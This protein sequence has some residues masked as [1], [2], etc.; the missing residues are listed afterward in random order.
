MHFLTRLSRKYDAVATVKRKHLLFIPIKGIKNSKSEKLPTFHITWCDGDQHPW[1]S[2]T[3]DAF[4]GVKAY[5]SDSVNGKRKLVVAGK[6]E[7]NT[8][9]LKE[10]YAS[11]KDALDAAP[12]PSANASSAAWAR[13]S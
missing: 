11:E 12:R 1:S 10:T 2:S 9:T 4:D 7:G 8:T 3:G 6:K 5:W 13:L